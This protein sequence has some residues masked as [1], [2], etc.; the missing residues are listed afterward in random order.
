MS[1]EGF[2]FDGP[3]VARRDAARLSDQLLMVRALMMD[4]RWRTLAEIAEKTK[5]SEA[6]VS[7]R[8]RDLRKARFGGNIVERR[9][10]SPS[11]G[12]WEYRLFL[13][14]AP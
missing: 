1:Q 9:R 12:L 4:G 6:G 3:D 5:G 2:R 14:S 10:R 8:L 11:V 13:R 7:A